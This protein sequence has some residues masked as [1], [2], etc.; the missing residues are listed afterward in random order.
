MK[1]NKMRLSNVL[2]SS[3]DSVTFEDGAKGSVLGSRSLNVPGLPNLRDVLIVDGLKSN[4]INI[5]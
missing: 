4:L 5:S 1:S 2:P 3:L